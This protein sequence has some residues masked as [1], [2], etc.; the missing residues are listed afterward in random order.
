MGKEFEFYYDYVSPTSYL[1]WTQLP[2]LVQRT[3]ASVLYKPALLGGIF[4]STGN[5]APISVPAKGVWLANDMARFATRYGVTFNM[6]PNFP[7]SSVYLMRGAI[8]A[9]QMGVIEDFN[10]VMFNGIWVD[11]ADMTDPSALGK[12]LNKA[13]IDSQAI[14]ASMQDPEI[15]QALFDRTEEAVAKGLFGMPTFL[16]GGE[17]HWGQDRIDFV[18]EALLRS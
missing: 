14:M 5:R 18:E 13:G 7:F 3:G 8:K 16:V 1:A 12:M 15:K 4:K 11:N 9:L 6:H 2:A 10:T 17:L